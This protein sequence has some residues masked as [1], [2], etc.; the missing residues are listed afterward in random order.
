MVGSGLIGNWP[1][2]QHPTLPQV[3]DALRYSVSLEK[4]QSD[5]DRP[6]IG[7]LLWAYICRIASEGCSV[8]LSPCPQHDI[9]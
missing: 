7:A 4:P 8:I 3:R 2:A 1:A 5:S 6:K 9:G